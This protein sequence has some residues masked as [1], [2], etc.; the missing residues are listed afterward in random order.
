ML[1]CLSVL[2]DRYRINMRLHIFVVS[3]LVF[4]DSCCEVLVFVIYIFFKLTNM[5][6]EKQSQ[7]S[8]LK[9]LISEFGDNVFSADGRI[10]F[11]KV[12]K[13]KVEYEQGDLV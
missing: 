8:R 11:Y 13:F 7:I 9:S 1:F 12:C 6:K 2:G 5:P 10:L 4:R 3:V